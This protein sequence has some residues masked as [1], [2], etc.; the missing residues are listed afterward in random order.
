MLLMTA[1]CLRWCHGD[2]TAKKALKSS[3]PSSQSGR[4]S[5]AGTQ[6]MLLAK[7]RRPT[8][9]S[10]GVGEKKKIKLVMQNET[11]SSISSSGG[12][13][14]K[15]ILKR[16]PLI[17]FIKSQ[18]IR[19]V[20]SEKLRILWPG[21]EIKHISHQSEMRGKQTVRWRRRYRF[22]NVLIGIAVY[23]RA[24]KWI[25]ARGRFLAT[26]NTHSW[27]GRLGNGRGDS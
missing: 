13:T 20:I 22:V 4:C 14:E 6:P 19:T 17:Q 3:V 21:R 9:Q 15:I 25:P 27:R 10:W 5:M 24:E 7:N 1:R 16:T 2:K 18:G 26:E 12:R 23:F 11:L 8:K